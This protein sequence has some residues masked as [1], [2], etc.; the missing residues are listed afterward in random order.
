[1]VSS[2]FSSKPYK[3]M[4]VILMINILAVPVLAQEVEKTPPQ[5]QE[6]SDY[7]QICETAKVDANADGGTTGYAI[8]G[9]LCG[10]FGYL[11]AAASAPQ[12]PA[13]RL[14]GK[15]A[16]Y[17]QAYSS[18]YEKQA[19]KIRKSAACTGWAIG[20]SVSLLYLALSGGFES[21]TSTY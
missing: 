21:G 18:C 16:N 3:I 15:D 14:V 4:A 13:S 6:Q 11:I 1:M 17:V 12:V 5:P 2:F 20:S 7:T 8:G 10:I 19:K 9:F